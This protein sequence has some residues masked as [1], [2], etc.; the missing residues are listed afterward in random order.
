MSLRSNGTRPVVAV[1]SSLGRLR[2]RLTAWYVGTFF[3]ILALLGV[4]M[5][6]TITRR[7]DRELDESLR[8]ATNELARV[9]RLRDSAPNQG[10]PLFD[11]ANDFRI[12]ERTLFLVDSSGRASS[13]AQPPEWIQPLA[14]DAARSGTASR[15]QAGQEEGILRAYAERV[16]LPGGRPVV[17]IAIAN[18]IELEDRYASLIAAFGAAAIVALL[19]VAGG[20]WMLARQSTAPV[21]RAIVQMRQFMADAAHELRTPL[22]VVRSRAEVAVQRPRGQEEYLAALRSIERESERLG[23]IV[24]DLLTLARADAGERTIERRRVFFDDVTLD[25]AEAVRVIADRKSVRLEVDDF[26]EAP[27]EGDANLLR[28]LAIIL[29]DNAIKF[30]PGGG[31][32][33]IGVRSTGSVAELAVSDTGI[34]IEPDKLPHVFDRFFRAD[35]SRT[36]ATPDASAASE[37]VGLGL[38][39]ARWI[40]DEHGGTISIDSDVGRGTRVVVQF[41]RAVPVESVSSS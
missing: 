23:R 1:P 30:T 31:V 36:R 3:V 4:G 28:Q 25:A 7:F 9:A 38:A 24:E 5:F 29:L 12:P 16:D 22:A 37:G 18:E 39:I 17:A 19:L 2:L 10:R 33:R 27:V 26:E 8:D 11:A 13:G 21:E 35:T 14:R 15:T 41:P 40:V 6:A 32:V 34:G 20:G